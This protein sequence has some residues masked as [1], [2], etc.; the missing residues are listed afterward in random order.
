MHKYF[1][2]I[3]LIIFLFL[4]KISTGNWSSSVLLVGNNKNYEKN[5][6][7]FMPFKIRQIKQKFDKNDKKIGSNTSTMKTNA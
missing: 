2:F 3:F 5:I 6:L 4:F 1:L 7:R